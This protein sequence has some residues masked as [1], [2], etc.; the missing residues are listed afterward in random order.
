MGLVG[1]EDGVVVAG[2]GAGFGF[3]GGVGDAIAARGGFERGDGAVQ[4]GY[5][6]DDGVNGQRVLRG[7]KRPYMQVVD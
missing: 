3:D 5:V 2:W 7:R 6:G 4:P 1:G